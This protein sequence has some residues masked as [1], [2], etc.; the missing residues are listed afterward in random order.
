MTYL[1]EALA[2]AVERCVCENVSPVSSQLVLAAIT[3]VAEAL[4][5]TELLRA[6]LAARTAL[7]PNDMDG[8]H[9]V[10]QAWQ[11]ERAAP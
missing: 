6:L 2:R 9:A 5:E 3:G 1:G 10:L 4:G 11:R 7:W 8:Y